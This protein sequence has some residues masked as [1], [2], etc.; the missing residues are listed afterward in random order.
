[1]SSCGASLKSS[2]HFPTVRYLVQYVTGTHERYGSTVA[3]T[4]RTF[5]PETQAQR[6][7][8]I[9]TRLIHPT[10][11]VE[12]RGKVNYEYCAQ[13]RRGTPTKDFDNAM[14]SLESI[15]SIAQNSRY[16]KTEPNPAMYLHT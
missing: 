7:Q 11:R 13:P 14:N 1:M 6:K 10:I 8:T 16:L 5:V 4:V 2:G 9:E 12:I 15:D 3:T